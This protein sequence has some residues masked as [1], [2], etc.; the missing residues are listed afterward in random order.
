MS[1]FSIK[2]IAKASDIRVHINPG[3]GGKPMNISF[4]C[5]LFSN[6]GDKISTESMDTKM[7]L[8]EMITTNL[9]DP[10]L[11]DM[12]GQHG[13]MH[14]ATSVNIHSTKHELHEFIVTFGAYGTT[15]NLIDY[16]DHTIDKSMEY[17][18][19]TDE[20]KAAMNE[21]ESLMTRLELV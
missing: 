2:N 4:R 16:Q 21:Y 12:Y 7:W 14:K 15:I 13:F 3:W 10:D 20:Y 19:T 8:G 9:T 11:V 1:K 6:T 5:D 17:I 18:K